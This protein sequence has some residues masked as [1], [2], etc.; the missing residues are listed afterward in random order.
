MATD[1][2]SSAGE[3]G[4]SDIVPREHKRTFDAI[5]RKEATKQRH[6]NGKAGSGGSG[7]GSAGGSLGSGSRITARL[8][9]PLDCEWPRLVSDGR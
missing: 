3:K 8:L 4:G 1:N 7:S 2:D 9:L 5:A 6:E